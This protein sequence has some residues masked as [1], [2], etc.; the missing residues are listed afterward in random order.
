M[1]INL[2][3]NAMDALA[4]AAGS[5]KTIT[6][7]SGMDT[8]REVVLRVR[9]TGGGIDTEDERHMFDPFYT[10]K[11]KGLGLGLSISRTIVEAHGGALSASNSPEGG[12]VFSLS[13]PMMAQEDRDEQGHGLGNTDR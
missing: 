12:A 3:V 6:V 7:Q 1:V 13:L 10:T 2:L 4:E 8:G 11:E 5:V 9:D